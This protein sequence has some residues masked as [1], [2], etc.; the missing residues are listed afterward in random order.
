MPI[1]YQ[2]FSLMVL[3]MLDAA[4]ETHSIADKGHKH[5]PASGGKSEVHFYITPRLSIKEP[6]TLQTLN[7]GATM[8]V[9]SH[10]AQPH[11]DDEV[12]GRVEEIVEEIVIDEDPIASRQHI[13]ANHTSDHLSDGSKALKVL[14]LIEQ[15]CLEDI[16]DL[17]AQVSKLDNA[18][19]RSNLSSVYAKCIGRFDNSR[20]LISD[21][22]DELFSCTG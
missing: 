18:T 2:H 19:D 20:A 15:R 12:V 13:E 11:E 16:A 5:S 1:A 6:M 8:F 7:P 10:N 21:C 22:K 4:C 17:E 14:E 3:D 9:P